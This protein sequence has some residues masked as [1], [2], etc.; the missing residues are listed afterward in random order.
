MYIEYVMH[1]IEYSKRD[2]YCY[3]IERFYYDLVMTTHSYLY[4]VERDTFYASSNALYTLGTALKNAHQKVRQYEN[5]LER[6]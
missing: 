3:Q 4:S 5:H 6:N 2:D 1:I